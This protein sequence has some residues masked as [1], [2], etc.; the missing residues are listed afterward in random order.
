MD[1]RGVERQAFSLVELLVVI[2]IIAILIGL[3]LPAVQ[4]VRES[5]SQTDCLDH[6][7]NIGLAVHNHYDQLGRFPKGGFQNAGGST[8]D[9]N[10]RDQWNW[11]YSMLPFVEQQALYDHDSV[12]IIDET[13][14]KIYYCPS[15]RQAKTYGNR[16]KCDYAANAGTNAS[17]RNDGMIIRGDFT[18][19]TLLEVS[20]GTSNTVAF[21]ERQMNITAFGTATDDNEPYNRSAWNGDWEAYRIGVDPPE[22]DIKTG[23][24]HQIFGSS[25]PMSVNAAFADGSVRSIRYSVSQSAWRAACTRNGGESEQL[26]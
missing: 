15:R 9:P 6:M 7:R 4:K 3:L 19:I 11:G 16:A 17:S 1:R 23:D 2:A 20:D 14:V 10:N 22:R 12:S 25:H 24:T 13:P 26:P 21:A 5:A 18:P 8:S